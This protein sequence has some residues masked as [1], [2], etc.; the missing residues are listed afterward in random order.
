MKLKYLSTAMILATLPATGAFAAALDRSGQ[1]MSAF[2][3]PGNYFEAGISV[4]DP[5]VK[6]KEAG[7]SLQPHRDIGDMADDYYFPSAALKL[8]VTDQFS[9]G[10]LYD[11]PFGAKAAYSGQN[12]FVG[13]AD[14]KV[15]PQARLDA[16]ATDKINGTVNALLGD[17][18]PAGHP[19]AA[20]QQQIRALQAAGTTQAI[21]QFA[22]TSLGGNTTLAQQMYDNNIAPV[23]GGP[24][25]K[26]IIDPA[27][28]T[29]VKAGVTSNVT[30]QVKGAIAGVNKLLPGQGGTNVE[31]DSQ[32]IAFVFGFQPIKNINLFAGGVYQTIKGDVSLRGTAYS[33]FNGY[34]AHIKETGGAGWLVGAAYQIP[35]IALKA[36]ITYRSEIDHDVNIKEN[37]SALDALSLLYPTPEAGLARAKAIRDDNNKDTTI[38]TPQSVNLDFQTG[39]M[40]N[41]VAFANVRW[42]N[43]KDFA[44]QPY[45]FGLFSKEVGPAVSRPNGFNLVEYSDDQ[46]SVNA[47]VGRKLNE[48]WAGNVSVGWDSGAGNPITTLGPTEGYWNLGLGVQYSP[49]PATFIAG[50]VKYFWLGDAKAQTGAQAGE[51]RYIASFEDNNAIA[52]GLKIGYRF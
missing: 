4:L 15:L 1:S 2:F 51:D 47:G 50:G 27:V 36:S 19:L 6:G 10:L 38:T 52:Y 42:V 9:F 29:Q 48:Q 39:I 17:T 41:T 12:V 22:N 5:T 45:Q 14:D 20:Q 32:N 11:Q 30:A 24:T 16:M 37:I 8:Q 34:D 25:L 21:Q 49:T 40:A 18:L 43:W 35:E 46:W 28:A 31:V 33:V 3:Q 13:S 26:Q 44:I 7:E 23:A